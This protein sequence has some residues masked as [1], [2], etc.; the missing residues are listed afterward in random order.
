MIPQT[1]ETQAQAKSKAEAKA[2]ANKQTSD[3]DESR[4]IMLPVM[5]PLAELYN[6]LSISLFHSS[7]SCGPAIVGLGARLASRE[8][9]K[10]PDPAR[11]PNPISGVGVAPRAFKLAHTVKLTASSPF[12]ISLLPANRIAS[13]R[14][15]SN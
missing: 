5:L 1:R 14:I 13:H 8:G 7:S 10:L 4:R 3:D 2:E 6:S 11:S 12:L 15:A 9:H